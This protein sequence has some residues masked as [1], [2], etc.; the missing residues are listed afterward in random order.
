MATK[1]GRGSFQHI[2]LKYRP[3]VGG[4]GVFCCVTSTVL[5]R[6]ELQFFSQV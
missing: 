5:K 4:W 6:F 1:G 3:K 2:E